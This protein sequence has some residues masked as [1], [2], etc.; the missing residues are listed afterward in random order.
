MRATLPHVVVLIAALSVGI[1][2][3]NTRSSPTEPTPVCSIAISPADLTFGSDGGTGSVT[4]SVAAGCTW[5]VT[6]SGEWITVTAGATGSGPGTVEYSVA[7]NSATEPRNGS[8]TIAGQTHAVLQRARPAIACSYELSPGNAVFGKD[9]GTGTLSVTTAA[10]CPWTAV[11]HA[12]WLSITS[13]SQGSGNG[14]VSYAVAGNPDIAE[15]SA[16]LTVADRSFTVRQSGDTGSCQYSVA[17]VDVKPCMPG[18]S[19]TATVTTQAFCPWTAASVASWLAVP[20]GASGNGSGVITLTFPDNYD[21]PREGVVQVRWPTPTAGQNIRVVQAGCRYGVSRTA[22]SFAASGGPGAFDVVQQ[23]D[24]TTCGG[25]TQD[26]CVWTARSDAPWLTITSSMPRSGDNP[27][28][29][30][31]AVNEGSASRIGTI[32]VRDKTVVVSQAGR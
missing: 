9:A 15:R 16:A 8:L 17:P 30:A 6:S 12:G 21:A 19:V 13:G 32:S 31:V 1:A 28:A 25:A 29:F 20:S 5:S 14:S 3:C 26:R 24:P 18:G 22:I 27:V 11:S 10:D 23:S 7:A 2:S 4:V